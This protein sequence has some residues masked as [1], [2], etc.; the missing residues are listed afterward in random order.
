LISLGVAANERHDYVLMSAFFAP[1]LELHFTPDEPGSRMDLD[2]V[3]YGPEGYLKALEIWKAP[4][5]EHRWDLRE[6]VDPGGDR[7]GARTD[8]VGRGAGSGLEVRWTVFYVWQFERGL[9]R[10]QWALASEAAMLA[11]LDPS[12]PVPIAGMPKET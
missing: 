8:V 11:A 9:L 5:G 3:Y 7:I 10:R 2:P 6:L 4:Y 1:D 12:H